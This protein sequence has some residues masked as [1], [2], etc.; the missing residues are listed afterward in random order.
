MTRANPLKPGPPQ[1]PCLNQKFH[2]SPAPQPKYPSRRQPHDRLLRICM[3]AILGRGKPPKTKIV[4]LF[5]AEKETNRRSPVVFPYF[6]FHFLHD[7]QHVFPHFFAFTRF[8]GVVKQVRGMVSHHNGTFEFIPFR[9]SPN[10]LGIARKPSVAV[11]QALQ[12]KRFRS[13]RGKG[14][15]HFRTEGGL[16]P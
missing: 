2:S 10:R 7:Q 13:E 14:Q 4:P 12:R 16:L 8:A 15:I 1:G 11:L 6:H 5:W 9:E 3:K